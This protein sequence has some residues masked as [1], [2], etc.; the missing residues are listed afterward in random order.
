[1]QLVL[2]LIEFIECNLML[3]RAI[4]NKKLVD[5]LLSHDA[6]HLRVPVR[7]IA[8]PKLLWLNPRFSKLD[9]MVADNEMSAKVYKK[10]ILKCCAKV[11]A[12]GDTVDYLDDQKFGI[13]DRY[14]GTGIGKNGGSGRALILSGYSVKGVGRTPLVSSAAD[15]VH[16]SGNVFFEECIRETIFAE[17]LAAELP[18]GSIA[19]LAIIDTGITE[20]WDATDRR[21]VLHKCLMV[22]PGFIRP[23]HFMRAPAFFSGNPREGSLDTTRVA[24]MYTRTEALL[25]ADAMWPLL[26]NL[27]ITWAEQLA[28]A[29]IHRLTLGGVSPSNISIYG[30]ILDFGGASALPTLA[31]IRTQYGLAPTGLEFFELDGEIRLLSLYAKKFSRKLPK[32]EETIA[33]TRQA[34]LEAYNHVVLREILRLC[35]L[36]KPQADE[37]LKSRAAEVGRAIHIALSYYRK[38]HLVAFDEMPEP[39]VAWD[40]FDVWAEDPPWHLAAL[41]KEIT[42]WASSDS[43]RGDSIETWS[44]RCV[45]RTRTRTNLYRDPLRWRLYS[46]I[47]KLIDCGELNQSGLDQLIQR[48]VANARVDSQEEMP[49][50]IDVG[51]ARCDGDHFVLQREV[52]T[53]KIFAVLEKHSKSFQ[54]NASPQQARN[55]VV[56][57]GV[58]MELSDGRKLVCEDVLSE[59]AAVEAA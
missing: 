10:H 42:S 13:A 31:H 52:N 9:P 57:R 23:A 49:G 26:E 8:E 18:H 28:F 11:V 38:E 45:R 37:L 41:R 20:T 4:L 19:T 22:R 46:E 55:E 51:F 36:T 27:A 59:T 3:N 15:K 54:D 24:H 56:F 53:R 40:L 33:K 48:E 17:L 29:F 1:M 30:Q 43:A 14:G 7:E 47:D 2:Y 32:T 21:V 39:S 25:G 34:M 44:Q 5:S 16:A 35:G 12:L 6:G 58:G 50:Y